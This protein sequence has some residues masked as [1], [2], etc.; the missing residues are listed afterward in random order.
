M[1]CRPEQSSVCNMNSDKFPNVKFLSAKHGD[2]REKKKRAK[3]GIMTKLSHHSWDHLT[4]TVLGFSLSEATLNCSTLDTATTI[5]T[6]DD[7]HGPYY[8]ARY[9]PID[10]ALLLS[11][12]LSIGNARGCVSGKEG[13]IACKYFHIVKT[14]PAQKKLGIIGIAPHTCTR[15]YSASM[16]F[17]L[18]SESFPT[19][20]IGN[21][22]KPHCIFKIPETDQSSFLQAP[23]PPPGLMLPP[24]QS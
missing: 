14:Q 8:Q 19:A 4:H 23:A 13:N 22:S 12:S 15:R 2:I 11:C 20:P 1:A 18:S 6:A 7:S 10:S 24:R 3:M 17:F 16:N 21:H 9:V 5:T